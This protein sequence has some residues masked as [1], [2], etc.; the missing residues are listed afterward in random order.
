[1][2]KT[3]GLE[4]FFKKPGLF[5]LFDKQLIIQVRKCFWI[6]FTFLSAWNFIIC[7]SSSFLICIVLGLIKIIHNSRSISPPLFW[8][9]LRNIKIYGFGLLFW[10]IRW[11]SFTFLSSNWKFYWK[12][13]LMKSYVADMRWHSQSNNF[14]SSSTSS[15]ATQTI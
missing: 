13:F 10:F 12:R 3:W 2:K 7:I 4:L 1:M 14:L 6:T 11:K 8:K 5:R 9:H 15:F